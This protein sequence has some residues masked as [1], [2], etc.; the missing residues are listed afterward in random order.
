MELEFHQ[1]DLPYERLRIWDPRR[2][3]RLVATLAEQGQQV[4]VLVIAAGHGNAASPCERFV[5]IDG[6]RRVRAL[7]TLQRDTAEA[8]V[9][10]L[11]EVEALILAHRLECASSRSAL[12]QG[13]FLH[14]LH[15]SHRLSLRA[16]AEQCGHSPS[17]ISRRLALVRAL[18]DSVQDAVRSGLVC[19]HAAM[20]VLVPLAR[21]NTDQCQ[22]LVDAVASQ[23][24][25]LTSRQWQRLHEAWRAADPETR[26]RIVTQ[27]LVVL[28][29]DEELARPDP[30]VPSLPQATQA[31]LR[32]LEMLGAI[33]RRARRTLADEDTGAWQP[34][35]RD[36]IHGAWGET[37][38][39]FTRLETFFVENR[40]AQHRHTSCDLAATP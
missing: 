38:A 11:G 17:W 25:P 13:W 15:A 12:E 28:R 39:A 7:R 24:K 21:A 16:L 2:Q 35:T 4:P 20:R 19:P 31:L 29:V 1:L 10:P 30:P 37:H 26:E 33:G 34:Q 40:D 32:D 6:Y 23:A 9:L 18:P 22:R 5:L 8:L 3:A 27:P 36:A 14:E